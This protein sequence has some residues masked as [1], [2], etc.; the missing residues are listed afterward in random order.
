MEPIVVEPARAA[1]ITERVLEAFHQAREA[2]SQKPYEGQFET[3]RGLLEGALA[4][5]ETVHR[6]PAYRSDGKETSISRQAIVLG[7]D[8]EIGRLADLKVGLGLHRTRG[9]ALKVEPF[10]VFVSAAVVA[11]SILVCPPLAPRKEVRGD[12]ESDPASAF[13]G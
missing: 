12:D 11:R 2:A 5:L 13:Q 9:D 6:I 1:E 8:G 3:I 7:L 4:E 10:R